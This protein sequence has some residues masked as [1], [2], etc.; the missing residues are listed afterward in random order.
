MADKKT[1]HLKYAMK[2]ERTGAGFDNLHLLSI[3]PCELNIN[4]ID[5]STKFLDKTVEFPNYINAIT[6]GGRFS[7]LVNNR[8]VSIAS[9]FNIPIVTGSLNSYLK[10]R[11]FTSF[12]AFRKAEFAIAN[13][14]CR[15]SLEDMKIVCDKL[16]TPYISLHLNTAQELIGDYEYEFRGELKNIQNAINYFGDNLIIK[17]VGQ[18]MSKETIKRLIDIGVKNIDISGSSGTNFSNIS[19][20]MNN[21]NYKLNYTPEVDTISSI[22]N[23]IITKASYIIASGGIDDIEKMAKAIALGANITASAYYYLNLISMDEE[24]AYSKITIDRLNFKK[25]MMLTA[26]PTIKQLQKKII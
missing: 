15:N 1:M 23:A 5:T 24:Q 19:R 2:E 4:E 7:K 20:R 11:D 18:G 14:S 9:K 16:N 12:K 13:L 22:K 17:A 8:L 26:S 10:T 25:L 3:E 6:G 21:N